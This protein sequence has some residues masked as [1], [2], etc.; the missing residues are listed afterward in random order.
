MLRKI[1]SFSMSFSILSVIT[2]GRR[3]ERNRGS[4]ERHRI[5]DTEMKDIRLEKRK[6][7]SGRGKFGT[8]GSLTVLTCTRWFSYCLWLCLHSVHPCA[9]CS[10][11]LSLCLSV[12]SSLFP[13]L[14]SELQ[15]YRDW[16]QLVDVSTGLVS[17]H[18]HSKAR[19]G[20]VSICQIRE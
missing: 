11:A 2:M 5:G 18:H 14:D 20:T 15:T 16:V 12:S 3:Y 6:T 17:L 19:A 4:G 7:D 13:P 10:R 1:H 9:S 8:S